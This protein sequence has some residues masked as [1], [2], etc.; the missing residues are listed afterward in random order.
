MH[1]D[2]VILILAKEDIKLRSNRI[3]LIEEF[4]W[5][6]SDWTIEEAIKDV[7]E[8][9]DDPSLALILT[10][11]LFENIKLG[12]FSEIMQAKYDDLLLAEAIPAYSFWA[13]EYL[14]KKANELSCDIETVEGKIET[15]FACPCCGRDTLPER[16]GWDICPICWW[17]DDGTDN[18]DAS[19]YYSGPNKG[20]QLTAARINFLTVGIYNPNRK[21]L[22]EN[23]API[24]MFNQS[25]FFEI[26]KVKKIIFEKDSDWWAPLAPPHLK[27]GE[28]KPKVSLA[29]AGMRDWPPLPDEE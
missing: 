23:R 20:L 26:D 17:E 19:L 5:S 7:E 15:V 13:N 6:F 25:R 21:D 10:N 11:G 12:D 29:G 4:H 2:E 8:N 9:D 22:M 18:A 1:R 28:T 16:H 24:E 27:D 3:A 14:L